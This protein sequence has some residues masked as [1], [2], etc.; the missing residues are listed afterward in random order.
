MP[1]AQA[2]VPSEIASHQLFVGIDIGY[3][4]HVACAIP[5]ALFNTKTYRDSWKRA[6]TLHFTADASGFKKLQRYLD[7]FSSNPSE[8]LLLCEPT[9]GYYGLA[10]QMYLLG[11]GYTILQVENSAVKDYRETVFGSPTKTDD[12]D[13]RLM[14]RMGFLHE[15]VGEE[16][17]IQH[18]QLA[19]PDDSVL[20][21]MCYDL[22]RLNTEISRRK[23]QLHQILAFTFP[24]LKTFFT[25]DVTGKAAR[26]LIKQ[27]PTPQE[28]Q[29]ASVPEVAKLLHESR[30]YQHEKRA[31]ELVS[32]AKETVGV[33][34]V[35]HHRWRQ[36]WILEQLEV[37]GKARE[38]LLVQQRHL[39]TAHPY[40]PIIESLP[41]KS[42]IWTASL[43]S[44]IRHIDRFQN[45]EKYRAYIGWFP[46]LKQSGTSV[47]SSNLSSRGVRLGR[48]VF[49]QMAL[50]LI[51]PSTRETPFR[52]YYD[53]LVSRGMPAH[54]ALGHLAAK[55]ANVL[56]MCLKTMAP[57]N[58]VKHRKQMGLPVAD[59]PL[60][61][62][63][64]DIQAA[65]IEPEALVDSSSDA[66]PRH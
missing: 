38:A 53:R 25:N 30:A 18:V 52:I 64:I 45:Y 59:E 55:L 54:A 66:L 37:L 5:G 3:E 56:Y 49:G 62:V 24:E 51:A 19:H 40:T 20:R 63:V 33:Q 43:I 36:G 44:V 1:P 48:R 31:G 8:F 7:K 6:K 28:L 27:Y 65:D 13:A 12:I 22:L 47:N 32:L 57:Y 26:Q 60:T 11:K 42:P 61:S 2:G 50:V 46:K 35:S 16:F 39:I 9:G 15:W 41:I 4:T 23:S 14:A 29:K 21:V 34:I 17:S 10:L 58:E